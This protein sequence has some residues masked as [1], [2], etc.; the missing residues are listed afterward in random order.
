MEEVRG[1]LVVWGAVVEIL[2]NIPTKLPHLPLLL[3]SCPEAF[4]NDIQWVA[5]VPGAF[6]EQ[7]F[8][9]HD[10]DQHPSDITSCSEDRP[11]TPTTHHGGPSS[12]DCTMGGRHRG[13]D[14]GGL[15]DAASDWRRQ[16][17]PART[18]ALWALG[19]VDLGTQEDPD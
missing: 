8:C 4:H 18:P 2:Q 11:H 7:E 16:F 13:L 1:G 17:L 5:H 6:L 19:T 3:N 12:C 14:C 9:T 10:C 15:G